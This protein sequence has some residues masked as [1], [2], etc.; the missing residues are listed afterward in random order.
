MRRHG[1]PLQ[2]AAGA[3]RRR[4]NYMRNARAWQDMGDMVTALKLASIARIVNRR[5]VMWLQ[6]AR[7]KV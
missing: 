6:A 5:V 4:D 7:R 2:K 1:T 3:R